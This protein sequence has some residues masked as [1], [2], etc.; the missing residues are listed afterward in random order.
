MEFLPDTRPE[1]HDIPGDA[2][3]ILVWQ[4]ATL[5]MVPGVAFGS[6]NAATPASTNVV[7][8]PRWE[9]VGIVLG[10]DNM[11]EAWD[12]AVDQR[13]DLAGRAVLATKI[14]GRSAVS[15]VA[16]VNEKVERQV[17]REPISEPEPA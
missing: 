17:T 10:A 4:G 6:S 2:V 7:G 8:P 13:P 14:G 12:F 16:N 9:V 3:A 11:D 1:P 5:V 15:G